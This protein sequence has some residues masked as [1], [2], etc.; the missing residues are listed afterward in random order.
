MTP[1]KHYQTQAKK[2]RVETSSEHKQEWSMLIFL[3]IQQYQKVTMFLV[4]SWVIPVN[5][6]PRL[7]G[8]FLHGRLTFNRHMKKINNLSSILCTIKATLPLSVL[9]MWCLA[10]FGTICTIY[11]VKNILGGVL[12]LKVTLPYGCFSRILNW[13]NGTK[14][15]NASHI[16]ND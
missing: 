6:K 2:P 10:R 14:S 5:N 13:T 12:L 15:R 8:V 7:L 1:L 4:K 9:Y 11:K 16:L 3:M